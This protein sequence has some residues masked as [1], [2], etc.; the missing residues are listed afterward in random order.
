MALFDLFRKREDT[1]DLPMPKDVEIQQL[2]LSG[3]IPDKL[4]LIKTFKRSTITPISME[5][6]VRTDIDAAARKDYEVRQK[7]LPLAQEWVDN[8]VDT[9]RPPLT[10][11]EKESGVDKCYGST[12]ITAATK[13]YNTIDKN[14]PIIYGNL[15]ALS[16][17]PEYFYKTDN[18]QPSDIMIYMSKDK[19][20]RHAVIRGKDNDIYYEPGTYDVTSPYKKGSKAYY[21]NEYLQDNYGD[22]YSYRYAKNFKETIEKLKRDN[23][24]DDS[25]LLE[26]QKEYEQKYY[27]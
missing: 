6:I 10:K 3:E 19:I 9:T 4:P 23:I 26:I 1:S 20:D 24:I 14:V 18:P 27:K 16:R 2:D 12:C 11:W 15:L 25:D 22:R 5:D 7:V 21:D 8:G 17:L 13:L